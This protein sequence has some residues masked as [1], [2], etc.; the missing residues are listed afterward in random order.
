MRVPAS[1]LRSFR[2]LG[3]LCLSKSSS[4]SKD[5]SVTSCPWVLET[6]AGE[7]QVG[8]KGEG[9]LLGR[10]RSGGQTPAAG[11][12]EPIPQEPSVLP[13]SLWAGSRARKRNQ[14]TLWTRVL[15]AQWLPRMSKSTS[16]PHGP[17]Q[18]G[19]PLAESRLR[20]TALTLCC[21]A[22]PARLA[23]ANLHA[24][25]HSSLSTPVL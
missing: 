14:V 24:L 21:P 19:C 7:A 15:R 20:S 11:L 9:H 12:R 4:F 23:G 16:K 1:S 2:L 13:I 25:S 5:Q 10:H 3:H 22:C 17:Q 18:R 8:C 6:Q